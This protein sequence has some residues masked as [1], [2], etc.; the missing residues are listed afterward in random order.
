MGKQIFGW[1]ALLQ[2]SLGWIGDYFF[3]VDV[4][5]FWAH[6]EDISPFSIFT[7]SKAQKCILMIGTISSFSVVEVAHSSGAKNLTSGEA[8]Q[9]KPHPQHH[10]FLSLSREETLAKNSSNL[11]RLKNPPS[12]LQISPTKTPLRNLRCIVSSIRC[13]R[14]PPN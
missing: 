1:L 9:P 10:Q 12:S 8:A 5:A 13:R 3:S 2:N 7:V 6:E 4:M 11:T 14:H